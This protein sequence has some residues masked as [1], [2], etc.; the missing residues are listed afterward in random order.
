LPPLFYIYP[1]QITSRLPDNFRC[2]PELIVTGF[3][4]RINYKVV[5]QIKNKIFFAEFI[6]WGIKGKVWWDKNQ[7]TWCA[8]IWKKQS[9]VT[10]A[11]GD[12][13]EDVLFYVQK[14]YGWK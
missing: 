11:H 6:A 1:M 12:T 2:Y 10:S 3:D 4:G 7:N 5:E 8:E 14:T 9:Y 13:I